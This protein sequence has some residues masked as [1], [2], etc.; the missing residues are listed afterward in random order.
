M[1]SSTSLSLSVD[2]N[3]PRPASWSQNLL[4]GVMVLVF[5]LVGGGLSASGHPQLAAIF[6]GLLLALLVVSS[7]VTLFWLVMVTGLIVAGACQLYIPGSRYIRYVVPLASAPLLLHWVAEYISQG[8]NHPD[9]P[10]PPTLAWAF[11][12]LV[13]CLVSALINLSD[14][15]QALVGIK[16]YFQMWALFLG[17][18]YLRWPE[19]F[20][21]QLLIGLLVIGFI[22]LP[23]CAHEYLFLVPKRVGL[24]NG[25]VP[26]DVVAGTFGALLLG[27]GANAVLAA[28]QVIL[29]GW[30]MAMWKN[31]LI[32]IVTAGV[33]SLLLLSP[34]LVNEAKVIVLYIP[35]VFGVVFYR[36]IAVQPMK[37]VM[38]GIAIG[39][40]IALMM[41][42][43]VLSQ[44]SDKVK[45]WGDL[46]EFVI[47]TQTA[48]TEERAG[49]YAELSRLSALTFWAKQHEHANPINT[50]FGHGVGASRE[51]EGG[52]DTAHTLAEIKYPGLRIGYTA[53]SA[54]L[55]DVGLVGLAMVLAMLLSAYL[56]AGRVAQF[57]RGKDPFKTAMFEGLQAAMAV[58]ALS[59]A[60]KDFFVVNLPYQTFVYLLVGFIINAGLQVD[61]ER[62][63]ARVA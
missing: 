50:V 40:L 35:L 45:S 42:A 6:V 32:S 11:G 19:N 63:K 28:Y 13:S 15:L 34:M 20:G 49:Q 39:G 30:M 55:W 17:I 5:G 41:T 51:T 1:A 31:G 36:D 33:V 26:V 38:G 10:I 2:S 59:L 29:S 61:R 60:H 44:P 43:L 23:F 3:Q 16:D 24:G 54:L 56:T 37:F 62:R 47:A 22:Q 8:R 58:V 18:I 53:L 48:D 12:F 46:V 27:G 7:R 14:P 52:I 25:I 57:Y 4:T 9:E 21:K